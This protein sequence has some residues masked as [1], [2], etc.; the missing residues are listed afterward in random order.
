MPLAPRLPA[1]FA[2]FAT[3][4]LLAHVARKSAG[5][6][7]ALRATLLTASAPLFAALSAYVIFDMPLTLCV[8]VVWLGLSRELMAGVSNRRRDHDVRGRR[9]W[10]AVQGSDHVAVGARR[11]PGHSTD[12]AQAQRRCAGW[13][14][15]QAG[16]WCCGSPAAGLRWPCNDT[17]NMRITRFSRNHSSA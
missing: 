16:C 14:V 1:I 15:G 4:W 6:D 12:T 7:Q 11:Q 17:R 8:T 5:D 9:A 2:G 13:P 3:L 10:R